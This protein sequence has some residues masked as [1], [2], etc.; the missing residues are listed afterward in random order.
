MNQFEKGSEWRKW[1]LHVHTKNTNKNDGFKSSSFDEFCITLFRKALEKNIHAIGITDYFCIKNYRKVKTFVDQIDSKSDFDEQE[2]VKIKDIF[3]LPNVELRM[4]PSANKGSLIN[5]HCLFNPEN[6]FLKTLDNDFF[7]SLENSSSCKMNRD[8]IIKLGRKNNLS[9]DDNAAYKNGIYNFCLEP[10]KLIDI[11]KKHENLKK[12]T[13]IVVSNSSYDGVSSLQEHYKLF[14]N[15]PG[16]LDEVRSNIYTLSDA[17]FSGNPSDREFFLG[18]KNEHD[19]LRIISNCGSLKPCIHGSDAHDENKLFN[20]DEGR[21]CWIKAD[22]T[23]EGLKQILCEPEDRVK[24]QTSKPEEKSGYNVIE[25]VVIDS[26][27]CNQEI[28]LNPNLNTIIGG[29]STGKSTLLKLIAHKIDPNITGLQHFN[30]D[31]TQDHVNIIWQDGE[32]NIDRDIEFFPQSYM[33]DIARNLDKKN[34]LLQGIV[35]KKDKENLIKEYKNFCANNKSTIQTNIDNLFKLQEN[36]DEL[37]T[38]LKKKGDESG[39]IIEI[40]NLQY[41]INNS[42]QDDSFSEDELKQHE[43]IQKEILDLEQFL[44]K[45]E[46]DTNEISVLQE[47]DLFDS[48][49]TYKFNQLSDLNSEAVQRVFDSVK[50]KSKDYWRK[51]LVDILADIDELSNKYKKEIED[52]QAHVIFKK[53][54]QQLKRNK[55]YKELYERLKIENK[56]LA[57]ITSL[58]NQIANLENQ[59]DILSDL[60]VNNHISFATKIDELIS[61]FSLGHDDIKISL[62]KNY[63]DAKCKELLKDFINLQSHNRQNFVNDWGKNYKA[64][65]RLTIEDFLQQALGNEIELKAYKEIKDLTKGLLTEYWFLISYEL[66]YEKDTF[67]KMSDGK[68]AFV[69]LK[70]LLD[71]SNKDCPILIDQPEDSLDNRSIYN[72]LVS[73]IKEKKKE[74]QIILVTHNSNIVVNADAEEV[75]VAN[76]HGEDAKNRNDLQFQYITGSLENT[77]AKADDTAFVLESQSIREHVCEILEGGTD[78]FIKRENKYAINKTQL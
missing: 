69:I 67:Q 38:E 26:D 60:T 68:K 58:K 17:I 70:L 77:K 74:R 25:S 37:T 34:E 48:S 53:G 21:F 20:P 76:Q 39:L 52:N 35:E 4:L 19:E 62:E 73:Y 54:N 13:I 18:K 6:N 66:T 40:E 3:L 30:D 2:R 61:G 33:Y 56:K 15:E 12:N 45:L 71:F 65:T 75:I 51:N 44:Q 46:N 36:I 1:D 72:K 23:F 47:E 14:I 41:R 78:A 42:Q 31:L 22:P 7:G 27:I 28:S 32:K 43:A 11:F 5:I 49:F 29:R 57:E 64:N 9:L 24:I 63:R 59:K 8:G 16:S 10:S 50:Q 55:E